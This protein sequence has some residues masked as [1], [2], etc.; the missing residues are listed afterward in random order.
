MMGDFRFIGRLFGGI[1]DAIIMRVADIMLAPSL[2]LALVLVAV[3]GPSI[4]NASLAL[5]RGLAALCPLNRKPVLLRLTA[6]T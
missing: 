3:F 5:T 2:L 4:V 1:V 6:T